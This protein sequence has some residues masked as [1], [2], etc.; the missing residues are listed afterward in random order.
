[1]ADD[2]KLKAERRLSITRESELLQRFVRINVN[3]DDGENSKQDRQM[4]QIVEQ[5][6]KDKILQPDESKK[7]R[8]LSSDT[9][10]KLSKELTQEN[11]KKKGKKRRRRGLKHEELYCDKDRAAAV[12]MGSKDIKQSLRLKRKQDRFRNLQIP[13]EAEPGTF[14]A[15]GNY[16]MS[17][18]DLQIAIDFM[19]KALELNPTEKN[20]LVARSKCYILLGKP[21]NALKDAEAALKI[22][23][24]FIKAIYQK[25]EALYYLSDFEHSLVYFHRGLHIRPDHEGFKLG[26]HKAQKAIENAIGSIGRNLSSARSTKSKES[27]STKQSPTSNAK[28]SRRST[29]FATANSAKPS[30]LLRELGTDKDYLDGLLLNPSIKCSFKENDDSIRNCIRETVEYLNARQEFWRQ[31]LP[32]NLK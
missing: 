18:G 14:L 26:V 7:Q 12:N 4:K 16:E 6:E 17:R 24:G 31:Q 9:S 22:D 20:S 3:D 2:S 11:E 32:P 30:R 29:P 10:K 28:S 25:A 19:S 8:P 21:E 15:L 13:E 5:Q 1:M 27:S 23:K